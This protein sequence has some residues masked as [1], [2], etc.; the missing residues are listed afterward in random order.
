MTYLQIFLVAWVVCG[1]IAHQAFTN[2]L[3]AQIAL[4]DSSTS[5]PTDFPLFGI[6]AA[7]GLGLAGG[8]TALF[9][10]ASVV[11]HFLAGV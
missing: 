2:Y 1:L 10:V 6:S 4:D 8:I 9:W 7:L 3:G 5:P 11:L